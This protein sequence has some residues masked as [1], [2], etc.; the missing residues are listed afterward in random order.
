MT[1]K[2]RD[3][4]GDPL[5][6]SFNEIAGEPGKFMIKT[7]Q[8][9][10]DAIYERNLALKNSGMQGNFQFGRQLASIPVR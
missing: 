3:N 4:T 8:P 9:G 10:E 7:E 1:V 5:K 2:I 6:W